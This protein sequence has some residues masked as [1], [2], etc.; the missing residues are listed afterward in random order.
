MATRLEE[1]IDN[2]VQNYAAS[3]EE[4]GVDLLV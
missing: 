4:T 3:P 1:I 2:G